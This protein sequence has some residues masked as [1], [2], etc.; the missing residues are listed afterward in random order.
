VVT[1]P[2]YIQG[3]YNFSWPTNGNFWLL[4]FQEFQNLFDY[5]GMQGSPGMK[6]NDNPSAFLKINPVAS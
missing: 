3:L 1:Y 5:L 4:I 2:W 6:R